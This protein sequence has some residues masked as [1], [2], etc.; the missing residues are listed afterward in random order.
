MRPQ[1]GKGRKEKMI[2]GNMHVNL[3]IDRLFTLCF[4]VHSRVHYPMWSNKIV[5]CSLN[6]EQKWI[7]ATG[8]EKRNKLYTT[9][10]QTLDKEKKI[11]NQANKLT[12]IEILEQGNC[13]RYT[14]TY[15]DFQ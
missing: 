10:N 8:K 1:K 9:W 3:G 4:S 7:S 15:K 5:T 6:Y 11:A 13:K 12:I 2:Q 14:L